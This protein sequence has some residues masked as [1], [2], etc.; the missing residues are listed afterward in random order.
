MGGPCRLAGSSL[1]GDHTAALCKSQIRN[2]NQKIQ[3]LHGLVAMYLK[4]EFPNNL[5]TAV[6]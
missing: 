2:N 4:I 3:I 6:K 1:R 5:K